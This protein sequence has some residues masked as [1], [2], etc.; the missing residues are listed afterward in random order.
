RLREEEAMRARPA[1]RPHRSVAG[2]SRSQ[3]GEAGLCRRHDHLRQRDHRA[4][5]GEEPTRQGAGVRP[6][7]GH[8]SGWRAGILV[9][10]LHLRRSP[11]SLE[12]ADARGDRHIDRTDR[13]R[14]TALQSARTARARRRMRRA[15]A[16]RRLH[17]PRLAGAAAVAGRV[18]LELRGCRVVAHADERHHGGPADPV[19]AGGRAARHAHRARRPPR[20][21]RGWLK[22]GRGRPWGF[23]YIVAGLSE[24]FAVLVVALLLA[25]LGASTQHGLASALVARA[26]PGARSLTA[27]GTYN[28]AGDIGKMALPAA[29]TALLL[30]MP[31][32]PAYALLGFIGIVPG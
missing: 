4:A 10:E 30:V 1:G 28:F 19:R 3:M 23:G 18:R 21:G 20:A 9:R 5:R 32:R 17:R 13:V 31:W 11:H 26:F 16:A 8:Q 14:R 7:Q 6:Q 2:L 29:A 12:G 27:L 24:G 22:P 15:R 25:G